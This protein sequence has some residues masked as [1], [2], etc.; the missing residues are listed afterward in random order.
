[1]DTAEYRH[2]PYDS[3]E[4]APARQI[5]ATAMRRR[6]VFLPA[7]P[8]AS[9]PRVSTAIDPADPT[10]FAGKR[11]VVTGGSRGLGAVIAQRFLDGGATV[12]VTARSA[13]ASSRFRTENGSTRSTS[14]TC[15]QS[16]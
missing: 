6:L 9:D 8:P 15:R 12:V 1:M 5:A 16:G 11:V 14:T 2:A 7:S 3:D 10:E 4:Y 13:T